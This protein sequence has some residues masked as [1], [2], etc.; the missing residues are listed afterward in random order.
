MM[1]YNGT[2][3]FRI[4]VIGTHR[5]LRVV[6]DEGNN[7]TALDK[8]PA[9]VALSLRPYSGDLFRTRVF[10]DFTVCAYTKSVPGVMQSVHLEDARNIRVEAD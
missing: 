6:D 5:L 1:L 8:L 7:L 3:S 9:P 4:W 2:F 10:A